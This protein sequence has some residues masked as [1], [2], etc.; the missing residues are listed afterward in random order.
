MVKHRPRRVYFDIKKRTPYIVK[1]GKRVFIRLKK[2]GGGNT[3][4]DHRTIK[5]KRQIVKVIVNTVKPHE[6]K[7]KPR[8]KRRIIL[9]KKE[10]QT[11]KSGNERT[12]YVP[13]YMPFPGHSS[14]PIIYN[15]RE[16]GQDKNKSISPTPVNLRAPTEETRR[17]TAPEG[18]GQ[19]QTEGESK[20]ER[21]KASILES[22][23]QSRKASESVE[24]KP[25][26]PYQRPTKTEVVLTPEQIK[27]QQKTKN[28]SNLGVELKE[29]L[30]VINEQKSF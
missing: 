1:N 17:P 6:V 15:V 29:R 9:A 21:P 14:Q 24:T 18:S 4:I 27:E 2:D 5:D 8:R 28:I 16:G 23:L 13:H 22:I 30:R 12:I 26:V 19:S 11:T 7:S 10:E 3:A 25:S 20:E